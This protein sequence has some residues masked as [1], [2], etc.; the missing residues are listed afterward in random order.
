MVGERRDSFVRHLN[1]VNVAS[2][3]FESQIRIDA[4]RRLTYT[5]EMVPR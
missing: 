1:G 3:G 4:H 2:L 5:Y